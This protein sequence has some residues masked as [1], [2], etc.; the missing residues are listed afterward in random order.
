MPEAGARKGKEANKKKLLGAVKGVPQIRTFE[1][2]FVQLLQLGGFLG[3][4]IVA[5]E[6]PF[7]ALANELYVSARLRG[8][9]TI[10]RKR[11]GVQHA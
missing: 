1:G 9:G 6:F 2:V 11:I 5:G 4:L 8:S 10:G 7:L 3:K